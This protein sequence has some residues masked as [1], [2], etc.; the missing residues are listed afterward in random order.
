MRRA[1]L[2]LG[3][4]GQWSRRCI[5]VSQARRSRWLELMLNAHFVTSG[6]PGVHSRCSTEK[7]REGRR[8]FEQHGG[9]P[10]R[11]KLA[12]GVTAAAIASA[13]AKWSFSR[14]VRGEI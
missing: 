11:F 5:G 14:R 8:D 10:K 13:E 1:R 2:G 12:S 3:R 7:Q 9:C 4:F 6:A